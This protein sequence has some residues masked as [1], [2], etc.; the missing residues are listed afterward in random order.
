MEKPVKWQRLVMGPGKKP[1][2]SAVLL[3]EMADRPPGLCHSGFWQIMKIFSHISFGNDTYVLHQMME[4]GISERYGLFVQPLVLHCPYRT[5]PALEN[6]SPEH[7]SDHTGLCN[8]Q[9]LQGCATGS[10]L[11]TVKIS[12]RCRPESATMIRTP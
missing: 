4:A 3:P 6:H 12:A 1:G 2:A 10:S 11:L 5:V 9:C 8:L 7:R